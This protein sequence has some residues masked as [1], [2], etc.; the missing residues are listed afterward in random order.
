[1]KIPRGRVAACRDGV[2][3]GCRMVPLSP[4]LSGPRRCPAPRTV[5]YRPRY[6]TRRIFLAVRASPDHLL[7]H[8][9]F[10]DGAIAACDRQVET[11]TAPHA[12]GLGQLHTI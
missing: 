8:I 5:A 4:S 12:E 9:E 10:L 7:R 6:S 2:E 1:M 11:L 3:V